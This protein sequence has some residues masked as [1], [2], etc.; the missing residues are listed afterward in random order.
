MSSSTVHLRPGI[1]AGNYPEREDVRDNW[2]DRTAAN[3]TGVVR[4]YIVGRNPRYMKF[5]NKVNS[6]AENLDKLDKGELKACVRKLRRSLY[7]EGLQDNLVVQSFALIREISTRYLGLRHHDVQLYGG[8]VM[9]KGMIAEM[10]TGEGKTLAATLPACTA[11][12]AGIPVHIVT[13]ND[14]LVTRDAEWMKP[15]YSALGLTVGVIIEGMTHEQKQ[16]AYACDITYCTNKQLAFDYLRDRMILGD[17]S[18]RLHLQLEGLHND[19]PKTS[20]LLLRGLCFAIID[21]ADSVLVD[22]ARTPLIISNKGESSDHD[23]VYKDAINIAQNMQSPRDYNIR[24]KEHSVELTDLGRAYVAR[25][26]KNLGGIWSGARRRD[27]LMRQALSA[28]YLH[29]IDKHYLVK[30]EKIQIIDEYTGRV[31][32][33]RSWERGLHQMVEAKEGCEIS[34]RQ[35]TL[36]RISYQKFFRRYLRIAGMTGTARE[37][38]NELW[39]VYSLNVVSIPTNK[40]SNRQAEDNK[41]F[42]SADEKWRAVVKR[43]RSLHDQRRPI[44][45]GTRSVVASEHLSSLLYMSGLP[46]KV[47]NARQDEQESE[48]IMQAGQT[49]K[50]T[51]ATNMAG[52][53]TDIKLSQ[54]AYASGGLFVLATERNETKRIDRQL[55]GRCGRQGDPGNYQA[56]ISLEDDLTREFY[57]AFYQKILKRWYGDDKHLS[58][59]LGN[60]MIWFA[61]IAS[62]YHFS[63][64]RRDL[65]KADDHLED[66]LA[67]T[68]RGE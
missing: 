55:F 8:W 56:I 2:L 30:D 48:I 34:M 1:E 40:S 50:I 17:E 24:I 60:I 66:M 26:S 21:E 62:D 6:Q 3:V 52:R 33:D 11:A 53:G 47:L 68:G 9:L 49:G 19:R 42:L 29:E 32:A 12:M 58:I 5:V 7:S 54:D 61:Q 31:M 13:V 51:V 57:G 36:A 14:F 37:V 38:A 22:E 59:R 39:A 10:E 16:R 65:L 23:R 63:R 41:V 43:I 4:Q 25:H 15:I 67:F 18:R 46:H 45:I 35:E 20:L 28:L 44:L 27:E 64:M